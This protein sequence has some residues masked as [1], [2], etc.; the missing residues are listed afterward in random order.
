MVGLV[1]KLGGERRR[2]VDPERK[3][4]EENRMGGSPGQ[5]SLGSY[6]RRDRLGSWGRKKNWRI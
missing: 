6:T 1:D 4:V 5:R 2:L 3:E